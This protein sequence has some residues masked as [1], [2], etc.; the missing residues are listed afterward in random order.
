MYVLYSLSLLHES[1]K[2]EDPILE[3][4]RKMKSF[5]VI[6]TMAVI[7]LSP[8]S[9]AF[10]TRIKVGSASSCLLFRQQVTDTCRRRRLN[11]ASLEEQTDDLINKLPPVDSSK[12]TKLEI[13]FRESCFPER[14]RR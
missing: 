9:L 2:D 5:L 14:V 13:E 7:I 3:K 12:M 11:Y 4:Y 1:L 6:M 10:V 8:L